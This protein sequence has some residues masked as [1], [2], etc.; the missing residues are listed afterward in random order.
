MR[1]LLTQRTQSPYYHTLQQYELKTVC[2]LANCTKV[3]SRHRCSMIT[4]RRRVSS[5]FIIL[6][7]KETNLHLRDIF[8]IF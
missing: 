3:Y 4:Q 7:Q 2:K 5:I 8:T 6:T 1:S